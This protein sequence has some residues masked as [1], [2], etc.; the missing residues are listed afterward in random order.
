MKNKYTVAEATNETAFIANSDGY[1]VAV[2]TRLPKL[3]KGGVGFASEK[4]LTDAEWQDLI[5]Q[6]VDGLNSAS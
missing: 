4:P 2:L 3:E 5:D 6:T 1:D